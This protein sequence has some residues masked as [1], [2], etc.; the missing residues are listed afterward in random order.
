LTE[1]SLRAALLW[2]REANSEVVMERKAVAVQPFSNFA[3]ARGL[4]VSAAV[5]LGDLVFVSGSPPLAEDGTIAQVSVE[6][7]SEIILEQMKAYLEAAGSSLAKV[8][9]CN[10]YAD[11]PK[12][13]ETF[14]R[15]YAQYFRDDPPARIF[16]CVAGWFGPFNLEIDCVACV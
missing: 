14:N 3:R 4:P 2:W 10:V 6:R 13:F 15:V 5:R 7:Q 11:D 8:A 12:H 9:K 1:T 16:I